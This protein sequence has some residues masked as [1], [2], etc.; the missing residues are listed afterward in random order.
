MTLIADVLPKL[1]TPKNMV[2]SMRKNSRF[3]GTVEK[4]HGKC[5]QTLFKFEGHL[6]YH[7]YYSLKSQL[8][9]KKSLLAISKSSNLFPN[10]LCSNG[11]YS[12]LDRDNLMQRIQMELSQNIKTFSPFFSSFSKSSLN[13]EHFQKKDHAHT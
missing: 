2:R 5:P 8:S 11:K 9:H 7:I 12:L 10:T 6:L 1:R 13:L 3:R 4:Q